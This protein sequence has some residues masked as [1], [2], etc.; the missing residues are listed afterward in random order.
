MSLSK[1]QRDFSR[2]ITQLLVKI[3]SDGY[4]CTFGDFYRDWR[5]HGEPGT[6]LGYS[7]P[8]SVHK[9]RLAADINLFKDGVYQTTTEAHRPFGE[10]WE[11]L[12]ERCQWGGRWGD[13]NHYSFEH[14][15]IK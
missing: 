2:C 5:V 10:W 11:T 3:H 15:G 9:F 7:H 6:K 14:E 13:G 12:D 4:E 8:N 1:K